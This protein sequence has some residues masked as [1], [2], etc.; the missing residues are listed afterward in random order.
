MKGMTTTPDLPDSLPGMRP[1]D[2]RW[3]ETHADWKGGC[4]VH[5]RHTEGAHDYPVLVIFLAH[6]CRVGY[7]EQGRALDVLARLLNEGADVHAKGSD[8]KPLALF[9]SPDLPRFFPLLLDAGMDVNAPDPEGQTLLS[10]VVDHHIYHH[11]SYNSSNNLKNIRLLLDAG[12]WPDPE[13]LAGQKIRKTIDVA[14]GAWGWQAPRGREI[15]EIM[16]VFDEQRTLAKLP[17]ALPAARLPRL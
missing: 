15:L 2:W 7:L 1:E 10:Q 4:S 12:A 17:L 3:L 6:S 11:F 8:G 9:L 13:T 16:A 5:G 14:A